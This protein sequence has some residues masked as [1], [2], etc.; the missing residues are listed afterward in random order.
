MREGNRRLE[1]SGRSVPASRRGGVLSVVPVLL[2]TLLVACAPTLATPRP[3]PGTQGGAWSEPHQVCRNDDAYITIPDARLARAVNQALHPRLDV[4]ATANAQVRCSAM[5]RVTTLTGS[6]VESLEGLQYAVNLTELR[7]RSS[8]VRSLAPLAGLPR[9]NVLD[10]VGGRLTSL[11]SLPR[12]PTITAVDISGNLVKDLSPLAA[13]PGLVFLSAK[14]NAIGDISILAQLTELQFVDLSDNL[15]SD[16]SAFA[17]HSKLFTLVLN[18]NQVDD[19]GPLGSLV[20]L[21]RLEL[22][23]NL[24]TDTDFAAGLALSTLRLAGNYISSVR[25]LAQNPNIRALRTLDLS[26]NCVDLESDDTVA[27]DGLGLTN[28]RLEPQRDDCWLLA[29]PY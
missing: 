22:S 19:A 8:P 13:L 14:D 28:L 4:E 11:H 27:L 7:L 26:N 23:N 15:I 5:A 6:N 10:I 2:A 16:I 18:D 21:N 24:L 17:D 12:L 20:S 29:P 9:L 25:S 1:L 3:T